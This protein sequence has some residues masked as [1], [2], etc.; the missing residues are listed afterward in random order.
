MAGIK[1]LETKS[2]RNDSSCVKSQDRFPE[3]YMH[4]AG[5]TNNGYSSRKVSNGSRIAWQP[6]NDENLSFAT[7]LLTKLDAGGGK[8][9]YDIKNDLPI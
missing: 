1:N 3:K 5:P 2:Y 7:N 6:T 4:T 9:S 8:N